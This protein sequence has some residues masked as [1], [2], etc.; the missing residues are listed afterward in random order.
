LRHL[1][2]CRRRALFNCIY[3]H[4]GDAGNFIFIKPKTE[5]QAIVDKLK[6][7]KKILIKT[8]SNVCEL[9][10]CLRVSIGEKIYGNIY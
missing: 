5:A 7:E 2:I 9:G 4:K 6:I 1:R 3:R 8:Y 10:N